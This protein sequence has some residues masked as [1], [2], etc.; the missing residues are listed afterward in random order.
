MKLAGKT[1]ITYFIVNSI[2]KRKF[3]NFLKN[4]F[5]S[6][7]NND[8]IFKKWT[9]SIQAVKPVYKRRSSGLYLGCQ[10]TRRGTLE[11]VLTQ[12]LIEIVVLK[13]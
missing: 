8:D 11:Y 1:A 3:S 2:D 4:N 7:R 6:R 5:G 13:Y 9:R 10:F 12:S